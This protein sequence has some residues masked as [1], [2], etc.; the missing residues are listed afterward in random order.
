MVAVA[1]AG[2]ASLL[3]AAAYNGPHRPP[4]DLPFLAL[5][6][7][8]VAAVVVASWGGRAAGR[9]F[10]RSSGAG[11]GAG[12]DGPLGA[13]DR[14]GAGVGATLSR[15][16]RARRWVRSVLPIWWRSEV[17]VL[18]P[19]VV[20]GMALTAG[21]VSELSVP[22]SFAR[23]AVEPWSS[24][25]HRPAVVAGAAWVV[26]ILAWIR[27]LWL[28][29]F[30][31]T[32]RH[33]LWSMAVAG[34]AFLGIFAGRAAHHTGPFGAA[35]AGAGWLFFIS[36]PLMAAAVALVHQRDLERAV[37]TRASARPSGAWVAVL[38]V[39]MA[40][41]AL[42]SLLLAVVVGPAAPV[43]GR[44]IATAASAIWSALVAIARWISG[45]LPR[46]H[47]HS[48]PP[49]LSGKG[50]AL[51]RVVLKQPP[52][53]PVITIPAV[54]GE[55]LVGLLAAALAF[56]L[57]RHVHLP[58]R[59]R[60]EVAESEERDSLFTWQHL[61]EQIRAA[62]AR[63]ASRLRPRRRR[64]PARS[65]LP[66]RVVEVPPAPDPRSVR[67]IYRGLLAAAREGGA[68]RG[69]S[70]TSQ[71]LAERFVSGLELGADTS[72]RLLHLTGLYEAVRYGS[73]PDADHDEASDEAGVVV[74]ALRAALAPEPDAGPDA[75]P[76]RLG[77]A[78]AGS[79]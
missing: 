27:G 48:L 1:E 50:G 38:A 42:V 36:F 64:R 11:A 63:L 76:G 2:W 37:L 43:L 33:A 79:A 4:V 44:A 17:L 71:E 75:H 19:V 24:V 46:G 32:A 8:A 67:E 52:T 51:H 6:L 74:P 58:R 21:V 28:G 9:L 59:A 22:G 41:V 66:S 49:I 54:V 78:T 69:A 40:G 16:A 20:I 12:T 56:Y 26:S 68:P 39:P 57:L 13:W 7:P 18:V 62:L 53:H 72:E 29:R 25:G 15:R 31:L 55:V 73:A 35:T 65:P 60:A 5:A 3:L 14:R 77:D 30:T 23:V 61:F 10:G 34:A 45:L 47:P 70:E